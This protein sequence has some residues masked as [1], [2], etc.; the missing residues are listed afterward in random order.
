MTHWRSAIPSSQEFIKAF[1][2]SWANLFL[3]FVRADSA[4][5][6]THESVPVIFFIGFVVIVGPSVFLKFS[7]MKIQRRCQPLISNLMSIIF[8][9]VLKF[10]QLFDG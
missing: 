7:I 3:I 10:N 5:N 1:S 2:C 9:Y 8:R 4:V 6:H